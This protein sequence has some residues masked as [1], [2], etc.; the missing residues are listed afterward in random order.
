MGAIINNIA[1]F[2]NEITKLILFGVVFFNAELHEKKKTYFWLLLGS[3]TFGLTVHFCDS[4]IVTYLNIILLIFFAKMMLGR[5]KNIFFIFATMVITLLDCILVAIFMLL[6]NLNISQVSANPFYNFLS[7]FILTI[8][9][10]VMFIYKKRKNYHGILSEFDFRMICLLLAGA[11]IA[12]LFIGYVDINAFGEGTSEQMR[13]A[14]T[15][16]TMAAGLFFL[17]Q[18]AG[19]YFYKQNSKLLKEMALKEEFLDQQKKYYMVLLEKEEQT[20]RFRHDIRGHMNSVR[21][22]MEEKEYDSVT[23]Y[24]NSIEGSISQMQI[25]T[26][27]GNHIVNA[28]V[29]DANR[30]YPNVVIEWNGRMPDDLKIRNMDLCILFSNLLNNACREVN[31]H[32]NPI[33]KVDIRLFN[34]N[35]FLTMKNEIKEN[36]RIDKNFCV[37]KHYQEGHGYGLR[38]VKD[39]VSSYGGE[40]EISSKNH[41]FCVD[42]M[43]A[44]VV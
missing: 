27:T 35:L 38:N 4:S 5:V 2:Y 33:V 25:N 34:T 22:L 32:T 39:C 31:N 20:K 11:V 21:A 15:G 24:L 18:C 16:L 13:M 23:E 7:N 30:Q 29:A 26:N 1:F 17:F 43:L 44:D 10:F 37:I 8:I 6:L 12:A 3:V 9:L 36:V 14:A 41:E 42:I 19:V 28:I 40:F